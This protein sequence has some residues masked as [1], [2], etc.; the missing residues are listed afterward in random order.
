MFQYLVI[1]DNLKIPLYNLMLGIGLIFA[2]LILDQQLDEQKYPN[3]KV[4]TLYLL[5]IVSGIFGFVG[6]KLLEIIYEG[7]TLSWHNFI[8]GG[9]TFYGGLISGG[10]A[11]ALLAKLSHFKIIPLL[12]TLAPCVIIAHAWGRIGCFLGGCCFGKPTSFLLAVHYPAGSLPVMFY[13][14][15]VPVHPVQLYEAVF[16]FMLFAV[17]NKIGFKKR[18]AVYLV[19][20]GLIRFACEYARGDFRGALF[21]NTLF[22][23]S[24]LI[25]LLVILAG[26]GLFALYKKNQTTI[27]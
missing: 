11:L 8:T 17:I 24:Q 21:G 15:S 7:K 4:V 10:V 19:S 22:S 25:S 1:M 5:L 3:A 9:F 14:T 26:L 2:F 20:Y 13:K 27:I 16:L 12:N 18:C 23:P 6:A